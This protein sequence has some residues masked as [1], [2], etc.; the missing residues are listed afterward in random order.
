M[1]LTYNF[2]PDKLWG[3]ELSLFEF[4]P[5]DMEIGSWE[6]IA[7]KAIVKLFNIGIVLA[8]LEVSSNYISNYISIGFLNCH[9]TIFW[10][11]K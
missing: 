3:I 9:A 7:V 6:I 4:D 5:I 2:G 1:T 11:N 10:D 8:S